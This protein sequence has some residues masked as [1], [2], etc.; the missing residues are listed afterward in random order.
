[1]TI[2]QSYPLAVFLIVITM[3]CW[4]SWANT[5]KLASKE[6]SFPLF[7]WDYTIGVMLFSAALGLTLGSSGAEGQGFIANLQQANSDMLMSAIIAGVI[8]NIA[9]LLLVAAIDIAGMAVAFPVAI[10]LALV[11]GVV[12][13]YIKRPV[14]DPTFIF[15][16]VAL[17]TLA[18]ILNAIAYKRM[19]ANQESDSSQ[20]IGKGLGISIAA[21]I[22]MGFFY[23]FI[24]KTLP[25]DFAVPEAGLLTPYT[26][27]FV[28]SI[29]VF[30]SSFIF[31]TFF[32]YKPI[33]GGDPVS[34][35][36]Y[37][38]KGSP[39][40]HMI[41]I[42]G[43]VIW[44]IGLS[45]NMIASGSAGP[46]ISYGLG[47]GATMVAAAWGVFVWKEF[48]AA[49][50]GTNKLIWMMFISFIVGLSLIIVAKG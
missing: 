14:G 17:V 50:K 12:D 5:Q 34:F 31:N 9:N 8:F 33:S 26:A 29:G 36:D 38:S 39:K 18:I 27:V 30:L 22:L 7:Y 46:A 16:G 23:G 44:C 41:G 19:Q 1:M 21:G 48:A 32:M 24:A 20:G 45:L 42:L 40:L 37:L 49:P 43:G 4:G 10:G 3:I 15:A 2:V 35:G 13:N 11:L 6:W 28:F 25:A 47:Q